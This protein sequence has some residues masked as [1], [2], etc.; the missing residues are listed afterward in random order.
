MSRLKIP[1]NAN[2][3]LIGNPRAPIILVEY[4]DYQCPSC[5]FAF[6]YINRL[7]QQFYDEL[8][9]VFRHFPLQSVHPYAMSAALAA[10]AAGK[11]HKFWEMHALIYENQ[12]D[13]SDNNL[14]YYA[15]VLKLDL[16][17]FLQ[18]CKHGDLQVKIEADL[19]SGLRSGV[20]GTPTFFINGERLDS[21][22]NSYESLAYAI[23]SLT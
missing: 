8:L 5:G 12:V 19:E 4:G 21:Y 3:H 9:Y 15:E 14:L 13:L 11:Q 22:D 10:E 18:D 16:Q 2:D 20:N 1:V 17:R 23:R 6:P 7:M